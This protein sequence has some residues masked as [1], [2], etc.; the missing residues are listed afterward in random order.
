MSAHPPLSRAAA[1]GP[2][3]GPFLM[4]GRASEQ[5]PD[6]LVF[7]EIFGAFDALFVVE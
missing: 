1:K 7:E 6:L 2:E 5:A 3:F 4:P